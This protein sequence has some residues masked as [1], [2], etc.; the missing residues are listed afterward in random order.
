[1][2]WG[3]AWRV[4]WQ[5]CRR[6]LAKL[7][8]GLSQGVLWLG[9]GAGEGLTTS[10]F[11]GCSSGLASWPV[12]VVELWGE[13]G[14]GKS[15][16]AWSMARD[17]ATHGGLVCYVELHGVLDGVAG[18]HAPDGAAGFLARC[19]VS[20]DRDVCDGPRDLER[21]GGPSSGHPDVWMLR[22]CDGEEA[23]AMVELLAAHQLQALVVVD[24][25]DLLFSAQ[26][27]AAAWGGQAFSRRSQERHHEWW[28]QIL[29]RLDRAAQASGSTVLLVRQ[30]H[31][32]PFH[33]D[34]GRLQGLQALAQIATARWV[35]AG[36][37]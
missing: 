16:L 12:G 23:V 32:G 24:H 18:A 35:V 19:G 27:L 13:E 22:P 25:I 7:D 36:D 28:L 14:V 11:G 6:W 34:D 3:N 4:S 30:S 31:V 2:D 17:Y 20:L 1:M 21:R 9:G 33:P 5:R 10:A 26:E 37:V 15:A 29:L 8:D